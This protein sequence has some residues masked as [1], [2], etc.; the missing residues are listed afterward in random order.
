MPNNI[1]F[2]T[3]IKYAHDNKS[4]KES[5]LENVD[6]YFYLG[7]KKAHVIQEKSKNGHQKIFLS[8]SS[9]SSLE[10]A[11]KISSYCTVIL[12][13]IFIALKAALR[14]NLTFK[15]IDHKKRLEKGINVS[16]ET[17][18]K[19]EALIP[20]ILAKKDSDQIE[21]LSKGN[22]LVFKLRDNSKIV[23]KLANQTRFRCRYGVRLNP[24]EITEHR[25]ENMLKASEVCVTHQLGLLVIPHAKKF[26]AGSH[27]LIAEECL[28]VDA[29]ESAQE[30]HY[31]T[32]AKELN[33]T[34]M[35]L[36]VFIAK[37]G[38]NDVAWRNIPV[39]K[40]LY[41]GQK[42]VALIDI[43]DMN[44]VLGGFTG[45]YNGSRGLIRCASS[46][47][48]IDSIIQEIKKENL[49]IT[50]EELQELKKNRL[51]EID[52]YEEL[53]QLYEK[54]GIVAGNEPIQVDLE[55]LGLDLD[56][57]GQITQLFSKDLVT[58]T[59]RKVAQELIDNLNNQLKNR[60][61]D[62]PLKGKRQLFLSISKDQF[63]QYYYLGL[64]KNKDVITEE[65]KKNIWLHRIIN[66]LVDK[67]HLFKILHINGG[68]FFVQA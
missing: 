4:F 42:R 67:K 46:E 29:N 13:L 47:E 68:G 63:A 11:L 24:N 44:N 54:K 28:E 16:D 18:S 66:A 1:E 35:Q 49:S 41:N 65:E 14:A 8:E 2:F 9:L 17:I 19:I 55:S 12:P 20:T 59:M 6:N 32:H 22:N 23:F 15:I 36:A 50:S 51:D 52:E 60:T 25:Y 7:G 48:Q 62:A 26:S 64:P 10:R 61:D 53:Y 58:V 21:W 34:F 57:E 27:T 33:Q 45:D 30:Q 40:D 43:E 5:V 39:L 3:A 31:Y 37:T 38:F 56:E